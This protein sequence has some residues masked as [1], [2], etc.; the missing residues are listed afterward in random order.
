MPK[1]EMPRIRHLGEKI[2][3]GK[4]FWAAPKDILEYAFNNLTYAET[5]VLLYLIGNKPI[6]DDY[7]GWQTSDIAT[8]VGVNESTV[9]AAKRVLAD[10]G[11][12]IIDEKNNIIVVDFDWIRTVINHNWNKS[13]AMMNH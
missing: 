2:P 6:D 13:Q 4:M 10:I 7:D 5:K 11:F 8:V 3:E 12:I 9:R 1:G